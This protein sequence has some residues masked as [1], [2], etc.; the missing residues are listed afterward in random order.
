MTNQFNRIAL[1]L[2]LTAASA[3]A[4][5]C[6][7]DRH[8]RTAF[9]YACPY[10]QVFPPSVASTNSTPLFYCIY[11]TSKPINHENNH[12]TAMVNSVVFI[13][14]LA[15]MEESKFEEYEAIMTSLPDLVFVLTESGRYVAILGGH[16]SDQYHDGA[17]LENLSL[18][19]VLPI[20]KAAW[21][22][23]KIKET[24]LADKLMVFE[25]SLS[26]DDVENINPSSG[27]AGELRFEGRLSPL[28]SLR[29]GERAVVWVA[30][31]ITE[32]Y[33]LEQKLIFQAEIDP[34][35][36]AFN[37]RKFFHCMELAFYNFQRYGDNVNFLLLD[38]DNFKQINDKYGH[39]AGDKVIQSIAQLCQAKLRKT[40]VF[41]RIGGDEFGII[42]KSSPAG[43]LAFA[44]RLNKL[45]LSVP[46]DISA[47]FS[48]GISQF[49]QSD[50]TIEQIYQRADL[51]LYQSKKAGRN[52]CCA[53]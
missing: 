6:K 29:Y 12:T 51:A 42:Y 2:G 43:S 1:G 49:K 30:R 17:F 41:G 44:K 24:L 39:Q 38:I 47:S 5:E 19:D 18:F 46:S 25:Y 10:F 16:S 48:I 26:A 34:L 28:K 52:M 40:D 36:N 11:D 35:S 53:H 8:N 32:R 15:F 27:P 9:Y 21:F 37:R 45:I 31:N 14:R 50:T 20:Q 4:M 33:Q 3:A 23:Q 7:K 13:A 22:I